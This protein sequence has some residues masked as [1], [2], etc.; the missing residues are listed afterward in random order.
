MGVWRQRL[1]RRGDVSQR[2]ILGLLALWAFAPLVASLAY[3]SQHGGVFTGV[4]GGDLFDQF[5]YLAWIRDEGG[6]LLASNLWVT[7]HTPHDY[8][9]PMYLVS[10]LVWRL[11]ASVQVAYLLWKPVAVLVLFLGVGAYVRHLLPEHRWQQAAAIALALFY[12][13]PVYALAVWTGHLS[14]VHRL[15][16]VLA[17]DDADSALQLWGFDHTAIAIGLMPVFLIAVE[18]LL[19]AG[20]AGDRAGARRWA[21]VAAISGLLVSWLY[22]WLGATL[23]AILAGLFVCQAPRRRYLML[24]G[25]AAATLLPLIYG[26]LLAH[27][28]ASWRAFSAES[29][30]TATAPWWALLASFGPIAVFAAL[31]VRRPREDRDWML[32]LWPIASAAV[33]FLVPQFPPH[34]LAGVTVPLAIL[35]ARGW[36]RARTSA[37]P[38]RLRLVA[39]ALAIAGIL[40]VTV[41]AAVRHAQGVRDQLTGGAAGSIDQALMRLSPDQAQ[42]LAF[43]DRAPRSGGVLA[44]WLL[45]MSIP[46][47]TGR[48]TYAGHLQWQPPA[49]LRLTTAFF[50][51]ALND[52]RGVLRRAILRR[53]KA[54]FIVA[55]CHAPAAI[56]RGIATIARPV[57][58]FG[59]VTVYETT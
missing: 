1:V 22:P 37:R 40:A 49:N 45:S 5:Q 10:G 13:S 35:A 36:R 46:A 38:S 9:E 27:T 33:Y 25:P 26:L 2:A 42:A 31:G 20:A 16:L 51:P 12:Q 57:R 24:A 28:D 50:D 56:A 34:A 59:C 44:P 30:R 11:G 23:L 53:T 52:P 48:E 14:S 58:T 17:S 15:A 41:P 19:A 29:T 43:L 3:V 8:V 7:G 55:D 6:H 47:F 21:G 32:T 4:N 18:K 54:S 39:P